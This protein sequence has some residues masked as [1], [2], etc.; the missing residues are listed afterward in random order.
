MAPIED[1]D[2]Y[3]ILK[4]YAEVS[5]L[6]EAQGISGG[7]ESAVQTDGQGIQGGS[8]AAA[9]AGSGERE[10]TAII[11]LRGLQLPSISHI[12]CMNGME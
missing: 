5:N 3:F 10:L 11:M 1:G 7:E 9:A 2:K 4:E 12:C 8:P 6:A